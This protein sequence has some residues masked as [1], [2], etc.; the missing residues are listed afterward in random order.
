[1]KLCTILRIFSNIFF[2]HTLLLIYLPR[3]HDAQSTSTLKNSYAYN[4][5]VRNLF[6]I[7]NL[8][9]LHTYANFWIMF[10]LFPTVTQYSIIF[11]CQC[12]ASWDDAHQRNERPL[13][14]SQHF[15]SSRWVNFNVLPLHLVHRFAVW[16]HCRLSRT[17][18]IA[19]SPSTASFSFLHRFRCTHIFVLLPPYVE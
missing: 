4:L 18:T 15:L 3:W 16:C 2:I 10:R 19:Q 8:H 13:V 6:F 5:E 17:A 14:V 12:L 1:M 11:L 9:F 7:Y